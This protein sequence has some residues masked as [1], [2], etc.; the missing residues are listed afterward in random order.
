MS[1]YKRWVAFRLV[2]PKAS[3][4]GRTP[5]TPGYE[6]YK[7]RWLRPEM[8]QT[9]VTLPFSFASENQKIWTLQHHLIY[10]LSRFMEDGEQVLVSHRTKPDTFKI[11][12]QLD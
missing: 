1:F 8:L 7:S 4:K 5:T 2:L 6:R 11:A 9:S 3:N 10:V 12:Y